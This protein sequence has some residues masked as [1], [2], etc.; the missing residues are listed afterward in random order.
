MLKNINIRKATLAISAIWCLI[1]VHS[2][3]SAQSTDT[4]TVNVN[5]TVVTSTCLV[6]FRNSGTSGFSTSPVLELGSVKAA[7]F[8][9]SNASVNNPIAVGSLAPVVVVTVSSPSSTSSV[10]SLGGN[11]KWDLAITQGTAGPAPLNQ[12][13]A[14]TTSGTNALVRIRA[15]VVNDP[16]SNTFTFSNLVNISNTSNNIGT[17]GS[18]FTATA[19][20]GIAIE[21]RFISTSPTVLP[22]VGTFNSNLVL[23]TTYN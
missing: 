6:N 22:T 12:F 11:G 20:S 2:S 23:K 4:G 7:D 15:A 19:N 1:G 13:L 16:N 3:V 8:L 14:S 21:A 5:G 10:C 17:G 9:V 18:N